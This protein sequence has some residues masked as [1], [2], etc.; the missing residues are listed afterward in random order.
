M[1]I[2]LLSQE[3]KYRRSLIEIMTKALKAYAA[4]EGFLYKQVQHFRDRI[5]CK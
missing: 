2:S 3:L 4:K 1:K 5:Q